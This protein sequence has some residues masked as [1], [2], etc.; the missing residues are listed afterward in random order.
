MS[1]ISELDMVVLTRDLS[2][3]GLQK[4]DVG[5]IVHVYNG[6]AKLIERAR[7]RRAPSHTN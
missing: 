6:G 1:M 3:H 7:Q 4:G 5:I 2:E